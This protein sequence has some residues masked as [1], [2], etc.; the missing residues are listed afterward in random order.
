M[1]ILK[2]HQ[3]LDKAKAI[4]HGFFQKFTF[5]LHFLIHILCSVSDD[6]DKNWI[7][8]EFFYNKK[9]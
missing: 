4:A 3:F 8:Y 2:T 6:S 9:I 1:S 5:L 7:F